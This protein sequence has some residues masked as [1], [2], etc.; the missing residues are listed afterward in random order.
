MAARSS[1][2]W[3]VGGRERAKLCRSLEGYKNILLKLMV[4]MDSE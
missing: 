4:V 1:E 2:A 3:E